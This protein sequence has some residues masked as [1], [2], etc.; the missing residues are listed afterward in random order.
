MRLAASIRRITDPLLSDMR[1]PIVGGVN[2][3]MWWSL[4]SAG[5]GYA[6]GR[7]ANE[8][9]RLLSDL[10]HEG[11]VMWDIGAHHG[12]VSLCASR[13]VG[14]R[15]FVNAFEP[16]EM[17]RGR[18]NRHVRWNDLANVSVHG[19]ALS[20]YN[21]ECTFGGSGTSKMF[22]MG[23]GDETVQVRTGETLVHDRVCRA[24]TFVKMDVEGAEAHTMRGLLPILPRSARL[25][26]AMHN[27]NVDLECTAMIKAAGFSC[28]QSRDLQQSRKAEWRS[29][30]DLFC[31]GPEYGRRA[32][33]LA[34]LERHDF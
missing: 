30:P 34:S 6:S 11:D 8:Q 5:S 31:V 4:M 7:R 10:M 26:I 13:K 24:P 16:S 29:D 32:E 1:V 20:N 21:G 23:G 19:F 27:A 28:H 18:L 17:N 25:F 15:G 33:D 22:A 3:G 12:Y 2:R 14:A 9:M